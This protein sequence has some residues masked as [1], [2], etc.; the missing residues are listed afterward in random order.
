MTNNTTIPLSNLN[1]M[2]RESMDWK[3]RSVILAASLR[4]LAR[5]SS[6]RTVPQFRST[7]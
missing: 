3:L 2:V 6:S 4:R 7:T 5:S 1:L